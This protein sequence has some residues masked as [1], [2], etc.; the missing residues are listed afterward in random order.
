MFGFNSNKKT[1]SRT[2]VME[3]ELIFAAEKKRVHTVIAIEDTL[4]KF[5]LEVANSKISKRKHPLG[6]G[7]NDWKI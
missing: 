4:E 7:A 1:A 2:S 6:E 3:N 5:S